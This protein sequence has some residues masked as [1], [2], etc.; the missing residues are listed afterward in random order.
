[1]LPKTE[2]KTAVNLIHRRLCKRKA[3]YW[4]LNCTRSISAWL[5]R[6]YMASSS[7]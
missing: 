2:K 3:V 6:Q 5:R 1:M 7:I 4:I